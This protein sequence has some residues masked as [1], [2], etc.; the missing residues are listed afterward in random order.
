MENA[1]CNVNKTTV[2]KLKK[3]NITKPISA[4]AAV[5]KSGNKAEKD[6][7]IDPLALAAFRRYF[8]KP[9]KVIRK[10]SCRKKADNVV[11]CEDGTLYRLQNKNGTGG[12]RGWS[13]DRRS[14]DKMD[15]SDEA[16]T[17]VGA[18]CLK[19][20][21]RTSDDI[22]IVPDVISTLLLGTEADYMPTHFT[23][24]KFDS[25]TGSLIELSIAPSTTVIDALKKEVYEHFVP[26]RTCVHLSPHLYFQRKGGG[27]KDH[28]PDDIQVKLRCFPDGIFETIYQ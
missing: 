13:V 12:G 3:D 23:H 10:V 28:A 21:T 1:T 5:A 20:G 19:K 6:L 4:N 2:S 17:L 18:V 8:G 14:L 26:K 15:V 24:T 11:E 25:K 16:R 7:C 22:K 27:S 9:I